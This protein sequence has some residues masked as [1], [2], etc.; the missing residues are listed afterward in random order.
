[1]ELFTLGEGNYTEQDIQQAA[2]AYTGWGLDRDHLHYQY[3]FN[4]HDTGQKTVFGQTGNFTGEDVLNLIC[5]KPECAKFIS[6][7]LWRFFVQD[8]P[9]QLIVDTLADDFQKNNL[10]IKRLMRRIFSSKEFYAPEVIRG[11]IKSP[12]QW[13][14]AA[15]HQLQGPLP[16]Q[17]MTLSML[18]M[19]GQELFQPPNVKGWDGGVAWITTNSLLDRYNFAAA[20]VEGNRV[21]LPSL[22]GQIRGV[23]NSM[24]Q[25][26]LMQ[27]GPA[28]VSALFSHNE[29]ATPETFLAALQER[30]LNTELHPHRL[31]SLR[32]FLKTRSPIEES[33]IRKSIRLMMC[34]PEYQL[35]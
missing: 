18:R 27:I 22:Q 14:I 1:M 13:I 6:A 2:R 3:H 23:L 17:P 12:V 29:L 34:T 7:R 35:T 25:D 5:Q 33:D 31:D 21:P 15:S 10:D 32:D 28:D 4:N 30:F 20:L 26:G 19:L 24:A 16:S 11:Q 9:P 8:E